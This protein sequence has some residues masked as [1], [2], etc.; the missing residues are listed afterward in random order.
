MASFPQV[1]LSLSNY[2]D[3]TRLGEN[4][5]TFHIFID[6]M[7]KK[8]YSYY[9]IIMVGLFVTLNLQYQNS[10]VQHKIR[11]NWYI[12]FKITNGLKIDLNLS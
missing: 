2:S 1:F 7:S 12:L 6:K 4:P 3:E 8:N 10:G 11:M 5:V 9:S